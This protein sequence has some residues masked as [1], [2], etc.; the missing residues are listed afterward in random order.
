M[1]Q[2]IIITGN[3]AGVFSEQ[4]PKKFSIMFWGTIHGLVQFKKL[5]HTTLQNEAH[6]DVYDYSV[7][8]MIQGLFGNAYH[9]KE[10]I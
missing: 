9:Q 4:D 8:K 2:N 1:I 5:E 3:Q 10:E 7:E 6:K